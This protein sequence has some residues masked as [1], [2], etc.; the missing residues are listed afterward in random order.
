MLTELVPVEPI[1]TKEV[2]FGTIG[3]AP[4]LPGEFITDIGG[5]GV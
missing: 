4:W 5:E 3:G 1:G 2:F